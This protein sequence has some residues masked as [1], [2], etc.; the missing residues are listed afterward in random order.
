MDA[1]DVRSE[2]RTQ[3]GGEEDVAE[4]GGSAYKKQ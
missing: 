3:G 1:F 2:W 4:G